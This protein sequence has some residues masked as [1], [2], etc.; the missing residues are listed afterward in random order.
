MHR[1][2]NLW[3]N[4]RS[5][6]LY[7]PWEQLFWAISIWYFKPELLNWSTSLESIALN[8]M[9]GLNMA[10]TISLL[11]VI[12]SSFVSFIYLCN[13]KLTEQIYRKTGFHLLGDI[14][15][16]PSTYNLSILFWIHNGDLTCGQRNLKEKCAWQNFHLFK[17]WNFS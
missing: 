12:S 15:I 6:E 1:C 5:I 4:R 10:E 8:W 2:L 3:R 9:N 17:F 14:S 7:S 16:F 13:L 11:Q